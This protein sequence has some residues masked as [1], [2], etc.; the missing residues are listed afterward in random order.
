M[1]QRQVEE[2]MPRSAAD[3]D[4]FYTQCRPEAG[5]PGGR[6]IL[7]IRADGKGVGMVPG[8]LREPTR[9]AAQKQSNKLAKRL[10]K[11]EKK[12]RKR[13]ATVAAV[14]TV[15]P[16]QRPPPSRWRAAWHPGTRWLQRARR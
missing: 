6:S 12:N 15:A 11:G 2:R 14:Y 10:N 3:F 7:V 9:K 8:D 16:C 1:G 13:M 4:A 5:A